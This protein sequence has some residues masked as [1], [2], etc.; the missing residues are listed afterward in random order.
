M[1]EHR[2]GKWFWDEIGGKAKDGASKIVRGERKVVKRIEMQLEGQWAGEEGKKRYE[3]AL[4][5]L[6]EEVRGHA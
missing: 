2:E 5:T 4:A 1:V 6:G 3:D